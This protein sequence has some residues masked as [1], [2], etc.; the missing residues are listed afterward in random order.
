M[1]F[2]FNWKEVDPILLLPSTLGPTSKWIEHRHSWR[3]NQ[4]LETEIWTFEI[5]KIFYLKLCKMASAFSSDG[6]VVP[7]AVIV[8]KT[9]K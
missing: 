2:D 3:F 8:N 5:E 4:G 7:Q 6:S 9:F 1:H